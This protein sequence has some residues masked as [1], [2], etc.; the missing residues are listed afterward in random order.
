MEK[1][2]V[3][4]DGISGVAIHEKRIRNPRSTVSTA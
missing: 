2:D 4:I 1:P 3:V